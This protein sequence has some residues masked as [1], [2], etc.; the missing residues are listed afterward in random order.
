MTPMPPFW[1]LAA[2]AFGLAAGPVLAEQQRAAVTTQIE[3]GTKI[4]AARCAACHGEKLEGKTGLDL[5]GIGPAYRWIGQTA[6]DLYQKVSVMPLGA[7]GSLAKADY[8]DLTA[9]IV[10]RNGGK[11]S[12]EMTAD[13]I[14]LRQVPIGADE[15]GLAKSRTLTRRDISAAIAGGPSQDELNHAAASSD[16]MFAT[17]DYAGQRFVDL[18][19]ID[20]KNVAGLRPVCL[21]QLGDTNPFPTSPLVYRG[22]IFITSRNAVVSIDA[23]SCKLNWR[24]DRPSR[25]PQA[26]IEKMNHGAAIKD[27]RLVFGTHDGFLV[28]LD[29]GTGKEIWVRDVVSPRDN[30]GGFTMSPIIVGDMVVM[31]PA[32]SEIGVKGWVGAFKLSTGEPVWRFNTIPDDGEPGADSW[33]DHAARQHGGGTVWGAL[34]YDVEK[35]LI[36]VPVS[37]PT[38]DFNGD[39]RAGA[40]LYTCAM[41]VLDIHTGKLVWYYQV[42]PHDTHDYDLTQAS[43]QFTAEIDGKRRNLVVAAGK[44]G[45]LHVIDRDSHRQLYQ[46]PVTQWQNT[47]VPWVD[48]DKSADGSLAC[49][50]ALGGVQWNGPAFNPGTKALYVPAAQWCAFTKEPAANSR[51]WLSAVEVATGKIKWRY[52]SDRPMLAAVTTTSAGLVF[53]GELTGDLIALD[54][55]DGKLLY[56]FNVGGP[57]V[58]GIASYRVDGTQYVAAVTGMANDMWQADPGSSTVVVFGLR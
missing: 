49:P 6:A 33:P 14:A 52:A 39:G 25:V 13:P 41:V 51:G 48:L 47:G 56:R 58:G 36:F 31:G 26:Y 43:P 3:R 34:T 53:G 32:G 30:Q 20:K 21:Y 17:H 46:T 38:P 19:Q 57:M 7:P 18:K 50:G 15:P 8:A 27:G 42:S 9:F 37:N 4:Y 12:A 2:V 28:A 40:N 29:A 23:A 35:G 45:Q 16:W 11:F 44:E 1:V 24:Y 5:V 54:A 55:D 10:A 22:A